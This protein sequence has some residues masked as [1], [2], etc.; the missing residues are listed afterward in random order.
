[1]TL[2]IILAIILTIKS[3]VSSTKLAAV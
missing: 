1:V 3:A 2:S